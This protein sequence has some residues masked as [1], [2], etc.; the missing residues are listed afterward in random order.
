MGSRRCL[1]FEVAAG[2]GAGPA[3]RRPGERGFG[4]AFLLVLLGAAILMLLGLSERGGL[5]LG[6]VAGDLERERAHALAFAGAE[7][8]LWRVQHQPCFTEQSQGTTFSRTL[9]RGSYA[10]KVTGTWEHL[11][12]E[13]TGSVGRARYVLNRTLERRPG[14]AR[15]MLASARAGNLEPESREFA[16]GTWTPPVATD[17][18]TNDA[19]WC[20][21]RG[22][23]NDRQRLLATTAAA[24][25][26]ALQCWSK[27]SWRF[28]TTLAN[29]L[30]PTSRAFDIA[31]EQAS[32]EAL[33]A[34]AKGSSGDVVFRQW[35]GASLGPEQILDL[36]FGKTLRWV[37][38]AARPAS[39]EIALL[40]ID[41]QPQLA[42]A[43]W[44]GVAFSS[45]RLLDTGLENA[46][47]EAAAVT[48]LPKSGAALFAWTSQNPGPVRAAH[49][50]LWRD[51]WLPTTSTLLASDATQFARLAAQPGEDAALFGLLSKDREVVVLGWSAGV[52]SLLPSV[53]TSNAASTGH[54]CFD[55]A[56]TSDGT[57]F[58][59][60][61]ESGDGR[62]QAATWSPLLGWTSAA[63]GPDLGGE[64]STL[65]LRTDPRTRLVHGAFRV[66]PGG[67]D[68]EDLYAVR[69]TGNWSDATRLA[70][71]LPRNAFEAFMLATDGDACGTVAIVPI[72]I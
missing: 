32:G 42:A 53:L 51:L 48:Y 6:R 65:Q 12:I 71:D 63:P 56:F 37:A 69:W 1:D 8:A 66:D 27:G 18:A 3:V 40:A 9:N 33:I 7:H 70:T 36:P 22:S 24:G 4:A 67:G 61:A 43:I 59:V 52:F 28:L 30:P 58:A 50:A 20:I 2:Q 23:P 14:A 25:A 31:Y 26:L 72:E 55:L 15:T 38:L 54:R 10:Y 49:G 17:R 39:D 47:S 29:D 5:V 19:R 16:L 34:Y 41:D 35:D 64:L 62:P 11:W 46:G 45:V 13:S 60:Y 21:L 68:P 57:G 44:N